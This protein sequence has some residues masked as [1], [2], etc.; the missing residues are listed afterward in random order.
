MHGGLRSGLDECSDMGNTVTAL[1]G[2][3]GYIVT[4]VEPT[5]P[6]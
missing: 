1:M 5:F 3:S 2:S 4:S 6:R